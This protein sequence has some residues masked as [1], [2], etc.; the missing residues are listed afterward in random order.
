MGLEDS[1]SRMTRLG[2]AELFHG[3]LPTLDDLLQRIDTVTLDDVGEL[4]ATVLTRRPA[5]AVVGP[6]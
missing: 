4:A 3:E 2:K 1:A 6:E 5:V